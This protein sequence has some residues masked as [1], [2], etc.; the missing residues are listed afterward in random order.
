ELVDPEIE[1]INPPYRESDRTRQGV[2]ALISLL[3]ENISAFPDVQFNVKEIIAEGDNVCIYGWFKGTHKGIFLGIP[4]T[5]NETLHEIVYVG[6]FKNGKLKQARIISDS[7][8][9]FINLGRTII[10]ENEKEQV[11]DYIQA[12]RNMGLLPT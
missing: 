1:I 5:G 4:P 3:E 12:V 8:T 7:L 6:K 10:I 11:E 9:S 2:D